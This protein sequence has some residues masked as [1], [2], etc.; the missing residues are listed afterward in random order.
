[1]SFEKKTYDDLIKLTKEEDSSFFYKDF[2]LDNKKYRIF[3]YHLATWSMFLK[4][5][6]LNCRGIMYDVTNELNP[7]L[8]SLPPEKF[9]NYEEGGVEH[10]KNK[11]GDK[12][13][14]LDGSLIS[15]YIHNDTLYLKSKGSLFSEQALSAIKLIVQDNPF[16][17]EC[18]DIIKK[19]YTI[20]FEYTSPENR[21]VI[22][23]EESKLTV[24]SIREHSS[25]KSFFA[26]KMINK[27]KELGN[28]PNVLNNIVS[29]ESLHNQEINQESFVDK[30]R[31][32]DKGEGYVVEFI[33]TNDSYL[34]KIKNRKYIA[35]HHTKDS[36]NSAKRLFETIINEASDDLR[37]MFADDNYVL[38]KIKEMENKV[39]PI[40]AHI[41]NTVNHFYE[42]NKLLERKEYAIKAKK[43]FP[44][45]MGLIMNKYLNFTNDYKEFAIKH[46]KDIFKIQDEEK[47]IEEKEILGTS[48]KI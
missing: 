32:E 30:I 9:F 47:N 39:I 15:T 35:L 23:Y 33:T 27:I 46:R 7:I 26:T 44:E 3:N 11:I 34:S 10:H 5:S 31:E 8:K 1:M 28:Y 29:F 14:K 21:I 42:E 43:D 37:L 2:E 22:P 36:V 13:E 48:F 38:N 17:T 41:I 25:G 24:L 4:E 12:M 45:Y 16:Y 6:A 19:G 40:Y 20:N 18:F